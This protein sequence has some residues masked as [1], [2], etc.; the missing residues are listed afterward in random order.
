MPRTTVFALLLLA[1]AP[2]FAAV[3][4][5]ERSGPARELHALFAEEWRVRLERD[6]L[7]ASDMGVHEYDDRLPV[8][9]PENHRRW[10][11][12]DREFLERLHAIDRAALDE[13]DQLN[14]DLFEFVVGSRVRLA[15][16]HPY[17]IPILSDDGFHIGIQRMYESMP[18]NDVADYENYLARLRAV[19][20]YFDVNIANMREGLELGITQPKIILEAIEPSIEGPIVANVEESVFFTPFRTFPQ[21]VGQAERGKLRAAGIEAI[22]TVVIP[23]YRRFLAFFRDEYVPGAREEMGRTT[24]P[25]GEDWYT[26]LARYY[27]TLDDATPQAIHELGLSEV[28]R[29]R[30]EM[31]AIIRQVEFDGTF[32]DF[33]EFLRTDERFYVDEPEDLLKEA[34]WIAKQIDG[35]MPAFFKTLPRRPY[36][37]MAVPPDIAPN[38]TTGRYWSA[39]I[40]GRR[41]GYY[42]VNTFA[43]DKRPLYELAALTAHEAVPGHHQQIALSQELT[44]IPDFRRA[45]Y[46]HALGEGWGLYAEKLGIEFGI[47]K[48]P[49]DHFGRL[50][51][52]MWRACRLVID[53]GIHAM[54]WTREQALSYLADN[55][56][57]SL[58][59]V[60]TEVD[61]Y[62]SWP[63]QALAYKMGELKILE[64]KERARRELGPAF[65]VREFHDVVLVD[66]GMTLDILER[67]VDAWIRRTKATR[68]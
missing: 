27:T 28:A 58:H 25:D 56:A 54:G 61:R 15:R 41:G 50:S 55:T 44:G 23:A 5:P 53:T 6:P 64:L 1:L 33:I 59:N 14:Y 52:E 18:F 36:G 10:L 2:S 57:L 26:D 31:D 21:H 51:Y 40:G 47:Y 4:A 17:R 66:G 20:D 68:D 19:G 12:E 67:R 45:F 32:A 42:L 13:E 34:S 30:R 24:F 46:P 63:G 35:Q 60:R 48:T 16:Y 9:T 49:Y 37:V 39:P 7:F 11:E 65:D 38:Y 22:E 43:L 8:E 3:A 29:I 62:I